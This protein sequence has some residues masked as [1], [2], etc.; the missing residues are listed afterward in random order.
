[1]LV[2]TNAVIN[3]FSTP[4]GVATLKKIKSQQPGRIS[5]KKEQDATTDASKFLFNF[6]TLFM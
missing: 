6:I 2:T 5:C 4:R 3:R 1:M